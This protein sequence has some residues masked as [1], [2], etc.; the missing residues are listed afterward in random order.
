MSERKKTN[1]EVDNKEDNELQAKKSEKGNI[2][3]EDF[4]VE[5]PEEIIGNDTDVERR[6]LF[7]KVDKIIQAIIP[8]YF[9]TF[10]SKKRKKKLQEEIERKNKNDRVNNRFVQIQNKQKD[11]DG[12]E[13]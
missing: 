8:D 11:N 13:N 3:K 4:Y 12:R 10:S 9:Y 6:E 7:K 5:R 2:F 1:E